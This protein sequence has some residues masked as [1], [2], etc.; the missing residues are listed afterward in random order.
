MKR[1]HYAWVICLSGTLMLFTTIGL[2]V[3]LFSVFQPYVLEHGNLSNTQG[4]LLITARSFFILIGM[5]T[6]NPIMDKL[7]LRRAGALTL[8]LLAFASFLLGIARG[9]PLYCAASGLIGLVYSWGG[10]IPASLLVKRWFH[11][12]QGLA[13]G[14]VLAGTGMATILAPVPLTN[15]VQSVSLKAGFWAEGLFSL[16]I[17]ALYWLLTRD[18]P[19]EL[20]LTAYGAGTDAAGPLLIRPAPQRE[21]SKSG[22]YCVLSTAFLVG[23]ATSLGISNFGVLYSS[24][25][26]PPETVAQLVSCMGLCMTIGKIAYGQIVD[27][28]GTRRSNYLVYAII[29][30]GFVLVCLAFT[31]STPLAFL[32]MIL[33]GLGLPLSVVSPPLWA[34]DLCSEKAYAKGLKHIQTS[35]ALGIFVLGSLPGILADATGSYIPAYLLFLGM[36]FLSMI[37]LCWVYHQ[38][39]AGGKPIQAPIKH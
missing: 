37:L 5:M 9:F 2:G 1:P 10:V 11:D 6:A 28:M 16:L 17:A 31:G 19:E 20:G 3:N 25:G 34:R 7:G 33:A 38:T 24:E 29:L 27:T 35:Y 4:S 22:W 39:Q 13:L 18:T 8:A 26:Y 23:A 30:L 15:L 32:A 21:L 14:I 36:L 12:R